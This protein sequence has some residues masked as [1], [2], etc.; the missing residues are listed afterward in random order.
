MKISFLNEQTL[1]H[2][3][4]SAFYIDCP[5]T[6]VSAS[7]F[8]QISAK[9]TGT[10][11]RVGPGQHNLGIF[12]NI[13]DRDNEEYRLTHPDAHLGGFLKGSLSVNVCDTCYVTCPKTRT[14]AIIQYLEEGWL[15]KSQHK[16]Q[17]VVFKYDP[18]KDNK[19][20]VKDVPSG[21][22]LAKISGSWHDKIY[23]TLSGSKEQTILI[24]VAPLYPAKKVAP[25]E[26]DQLFYESRRYWSEVTA[27]IKNKQ[28]SAA[29]KIKH[30]LEEVQ[31]ER[32]EMK[33]DF[34][35]EYTP[36]FFTERVTPAGKPE[37]SEDGIKAIKGL[38]EGSYKL[39]ETATI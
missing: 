34:K 6:G 38:N 9:F 3:P 37:L 17:G 16:V 29:T 15:G 32:P 25:P 14:K 31:R 4:V 2:P 20:K 21:D 26:E 5:E 13:R 28:Y 19:T 23:Y 7:G 35:G 11:I 39:E 24:D 10:S 12:I 36:R 30:D 33:P 18:D 27:A 1:H 8:D 22:V